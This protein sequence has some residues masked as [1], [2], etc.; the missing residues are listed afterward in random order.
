[1]SAHLV[2]NAAQDRES[3]AAIFKEFIQNFR[4]IIDSKE[5]GHKELAVAIKGY[6]FFAAVSKDYDNNVTAKTFFSC[7]NRY[8]L[9]RFS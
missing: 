5:S 8:S 3:N 4:A 2:E 9:A 7:F 1:M 6:G